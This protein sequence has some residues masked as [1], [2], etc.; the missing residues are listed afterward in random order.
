M[1]K[2]NRIQIASQIIAQVKRE[3]QE[4]RMTESV[5]N[6]IF[7]KEGP[8]AKEPA[9]RNVTRRISSLAHPIATRRNKQVALPPLAGR[10]DRSH[11]K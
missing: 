10:N 1:K 3:M 7:T 2:K 9:A 8:G 4:P 6:G 5:R 11:P